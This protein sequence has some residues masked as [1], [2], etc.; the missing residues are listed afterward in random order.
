M[1]ARRV[2]ASAIAV[3][4]LLALPAFAGESKEAKRQREAAEGAAAFERA[5]VFHQQ[6]AFA[7]AEKEFRT[8][9]KK[10]DNKV[11]EYDAPQNY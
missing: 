4:S 5:M 9:E 7:E 11:V 3:T 6:G 2:V 1:S 10:T 8:A